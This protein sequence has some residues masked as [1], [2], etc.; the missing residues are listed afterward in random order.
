MSTTVSIDWAETGFRVWS[1]AMGL[2]TFLMVAWSI[3][4][5]FQ[6]TLA[7]ISDIFISIYILSFVLPLLMDASH[8]KV[9]DF[10]KGIVYSIYLTPTY[11][12]IFRIYAISNIHD[13]T[14]GSRP[15]VLNSAFNATEDMKQVIYKNYRSNV[16]VVW[17]ITNV[18]VGFFIV[19]ISRS[20]QYIIMLIFGV[21]LMVVLSLKLIFAILHWSKVMHDD[22]NPNTLK[23][24]NTSNVFNNLDKHI[25]ESS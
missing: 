21:F 10:L 6:A 3:A 8:L 18:I 1:V 17:L 20:G 23:R 14:W 19:Y 13:V 15:S 24:K 12:N 22:R 7:S 9:C 2:F 11:I 16:F 25:F 5:A 4:Y